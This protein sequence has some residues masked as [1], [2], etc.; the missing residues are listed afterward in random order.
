MRLMFAR[1]LNR[2]HPGDERPDVIWT[3]WRFNRAVENFELVAIAEDQSEAKALAANFPE[4]EVHGA[5]IAV[6]QTP[7]I[8]LEALQAHRL[9]VIE[10]D[11]SEILSLIRVRFGQRP[12]AMMRL[13]F[14]PQTPGASMS[15][16]TLKDKQT[17]TA[18]LALADAAGFAAGLPAGV[19]PT[20]SLKTDG[21][22]SL[23]PSADG[24]SATFAGLAPGSTEV[25]VVIND[26]AGVAA[27]LTGNGTIQVVA[28][29]AI[30]VS[31]NFG[32]AQ[33]AS[34]PSGS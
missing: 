19:V 3:V 23:T 18:T 14:W 24:L 29:D 32:P 25:D 5:A 34:A 26:P 6:R 31:I 13:V 33:D 8:L 28:G 16:G 20:W 30:S 4:T 2:L 27:P 9:D 22:A 7:A 17:I 1:P 15:T 21:V 10:H 12:P 11:V